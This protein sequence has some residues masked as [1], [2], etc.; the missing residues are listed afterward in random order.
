MENYFL[1][2]FFA[3]KN[4]WERGMGEGVIFIWKWKRKSKLLKVGERLTFEVGR[5]ITGFYGI[6]EAF[7]IFFPYN[8]M[9]VIWIHCR[10]KYL[11]FHL[12]SLKTTT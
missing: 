11:L 5:E 3:Q 2:K 9:N 7:N 4:V 12:L 6:V 8:I 10:Q 1:N